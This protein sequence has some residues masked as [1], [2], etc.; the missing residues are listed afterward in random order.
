MIMARSPGRL[1]EY[2][3][4]LTYHGP[5]G[6]G[7]TVGEYQ[8]GSWREKL[9][10]YEQSWGCIRALSTFF[11]GRS[12]V[13]PPP[14]VLTYQSRTGFYL[15]FRHCTQ[16]RYTS[17]VEEGREFQSLSPSLSFSLLRF[18]G[19]QILYQLRFGEKKEYGK[20]GDRLVYCNYRLHR[21]SAFFY[22]FTY[23]ILIYEC[24]YP[25]MYQSKGSKIQLVTYVCMWL[26][27]FKVSK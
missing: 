3:C 11:W 4:V 20:K 18:F 9:P 23:R 24:V 19:R 10:V 14:S 21:Y 6:F 7:I 22:C 26:I 1:G 12:L 15:L 27:G 5:N 17:R 16:F 2:P 25:G 13:N 8:A